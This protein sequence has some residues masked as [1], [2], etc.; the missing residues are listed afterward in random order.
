MKLEIRTFKEVLSNLIDWITLRTD[1][2]TDFNPGSAIL[3]LTEAISL[4]LEEF[5]FAMKQNVLYAI[6]NSVYNAFDFEIRRAK[7]STGFVTID[8]VEP[9]PSAMEIKKGTV[10]CTSSKYNYLY[11]DSVEDVF[12]PK[13][14]LSIIVKVECKTPG[15][16]GNIPP[17]AITTMVVT[18]SIIKKV[19]NQTSFK[20]GVNEE[21]AQERKKRFQHFIRTL[22]KATRDSILY[23]CLQVEGVVGAYLDD[24]YVGYAKLYAHDIDGDLSD[25]LRFKIVDNLIHYRAAGIEI[26]VFPINKRYANIGLKVMVHDIVDTED[27]SRL[28]KDT[29]IKYMD[30]TT[31]SNNFYMSDIV[32]LVKSTYEELVINIK[33]TNGNDMIIN[34]QELIRLG[35]LDVECIRKS[36]WKVE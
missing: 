1:Y 14:T 18:N 34:P 16:I 25:E 19:Y 36:D 26:E 27:A 8:F 7:K 23:G 11:F 33:V 5:Y 17:D 4:Q 28:I 30:K 15:D 6:E 29:I 22:S 10:F 13:G 3:T 35:Q 24:N 31:V 32:H 20:D 2:L 21:T 9:L 12:A